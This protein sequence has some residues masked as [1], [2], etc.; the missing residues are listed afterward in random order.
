MTASGWREVDDRVYVRRHDSY[1]LNVGLV[2]AHGGALVIDTRQSIRYGEE[3]AAAVRTV[4]AEPWT[5]VNTHAHFDHFLGNGA[6]PGAPIWALRRCRDVIATDG[7]QQRRASAE[8]TRA[9]GRGDEADDIEQSPLVLPD[10]VFAPPSAEVGV[11]DR[12]VTLRH[13]GR[14][15]TDNDIVITVSGSSVVFAGDLVEEGAPP[16]FGDA[17]PLDWPGTLAALLPIVTGPVVPGH[18]DVVD[19]SFVA[20]QRDLHRA[21]VDAAADPSSRTV[22][23]LPDAVAAVALVRARGQHRPA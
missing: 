20:Q 22:P 23:G 4:T 5:V 13:L 17:F 15:H 6:F 9:A 10:H 2:V 8:R 19:A 12:I 1:D 14:G 3:L 16:S 21:V 7:E 11:G 18:G